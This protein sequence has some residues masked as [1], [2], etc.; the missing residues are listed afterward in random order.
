[1]EDERKVELDTVY[2]PSEDMLV[3]Q[4]Q[5]EFVIIPLRRGVADLEDVF[6]KLNEDAKAMW[7]KLDGKKTLKEVAQ[8]LIL[9][10]DAALELIERELLELA[11]ELLKMGMLVSVKRARA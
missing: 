2:I 4:I 5:G 11:E 6:F 7:D 9:E 1:M 8:E 10:Y 3:K